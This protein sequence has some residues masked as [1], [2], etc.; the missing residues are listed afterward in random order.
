MSDNALIAIFAALPPTI[1]ALAS[2]VVSLSNARRAIRMTERTAQI[3]K[4]A[5]KAADIAGNTAGKLETVQSQI[6]GHMTKLLDLTEKAALAQGKLQA[7]EKA[8]EP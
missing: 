8:K 5:E 4:A 3:Q 1:A 2:L 7:E 6:N